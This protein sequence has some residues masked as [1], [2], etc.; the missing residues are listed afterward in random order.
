VTA[1][2]VSFSKPLGAAAGNLANYSVHLLT[3]ARR[4][5]HGTHLTSLGRAVAITTATYDSQ[6]QSATL[7]LGTPLRSNQMFQLR[8]SGGAGGVADQSGNP[9]NSA[10]RGAPGNDFVYN[11]N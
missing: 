9:L 3:Q 2:I 7:A 10:S 6:S 11:L 1:V 8:V 5:K 4:P